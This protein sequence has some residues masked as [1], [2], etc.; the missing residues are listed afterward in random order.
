MCSDLAPALGPQT[1][2]ISPSKLRMKL[3]GVHS[4]WRNDGGAPS[5]RTSPSKLEELEHSKG[6]LLADRDDGEKETLE[7]ARLM[8]ICLSI[9]VLRSLRIPILFS[10]EL[11]TEKIGR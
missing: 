8:L 2:V 7:P 5:S 10:L 1:G 9:Y 11:M 3:L 4:H 6:S